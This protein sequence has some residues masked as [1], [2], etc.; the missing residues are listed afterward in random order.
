MALPS[1]RT[2]V[3]AVTLLC[4]LALGAGALIPSSAAAAFPPAGTDVL[5]VTGSVGVVSELGSETIP[6]TGSATVQRQNTH[7]EGSVEVV[8]MELIALDLAGDSLVGAIAISESATLTS[9]GELRALQAAPQSYPA[10]SFFDVYIRAIAPANPSPTQTLYN[11]APLHMV[12]W[13]GGMEISLSNWPPYNQTFVADTTPCVPLFPT[14]PLNVC[15]TSLSIAVEGSGVGGIAE[16]A[17]ARGPD[18]AAHDGGSPAITPSEGVIAGLG[19]LAVVVV[20][21]GAAW[22]VRRA[23]R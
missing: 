4:A 3:P 5:T 7:M 14:L 18:L 12:P 22:C 15:I 20:L 19:A 1:K 17:S 10:S 16:L 23:F 13:F 6:L 8:D 21:S 11:T 2:L 9:P